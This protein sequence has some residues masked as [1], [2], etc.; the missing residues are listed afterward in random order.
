MASIRLRNN[1]DTMNSEN[2]LTKDWSSF[3]EL[4]DVLNNGIIYVVL[5]NFEELKEEIIIAD[6]PDID[7]LCRD[8]NDF[9]AVLHSVSRNANRDDPVHRAITIR[10]KKVDIDIRCVGDGY[11]DTR[12]EEDILKTRELSEDGFYIPSRRNYFY[13]LLYH[14][15]I[16]KWAV[17]DDYRK[18]L[19]SL[20]KSVH[21]IADEIVSIKTLQDF[22]RDKGYCYVYP[23]NTRTIANF[24]NVDKSLIKRDF[25]KYIKRNYMTFRSIALKLI[26]Q[27]GRKN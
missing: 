9:L 13:S 23:E 6:H 22:M 12:W 20:G 17:A 2:V 18:R 11:L 14:V 4:W 3:D 10:G 26:K 27:Y 5:R 19:I 24:T 1:I 7:F 8:R 16:Q 21:V 15:L 25:I